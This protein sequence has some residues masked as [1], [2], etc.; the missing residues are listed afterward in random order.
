M[1]ETISDEPP[2]APAAPLSPEHVALVV[3]IATETAR[4]EIQRFLTTTGTSA[5]NG[6]NGEGPFAVP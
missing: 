3:M 6:T 2:T 4:E 1:K 5:A